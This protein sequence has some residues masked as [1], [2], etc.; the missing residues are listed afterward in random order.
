MGVLFEEDARRQLLAKLGFSD[1]MLPQTTSATAATGTCEQRGKFS[2]K[3]QG[4][5]VCEKV[6]SNQP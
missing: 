1:A 4:V 5:D 3:G 6:E 2:L